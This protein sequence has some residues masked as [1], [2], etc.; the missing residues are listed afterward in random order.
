MH[1]ALSRQLVVWPL[2]PQ[3]TVVAHCGDNREMAVLS[4]DL[5]A[6]S[7]QAAALL[8]QARQLRLKMDSLSP[9]DPQRAELEIIVRDLLKSANSISDVV[10][11][12][13][14]P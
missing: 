3:L 2:P 13:A 8:D 12:G 9:D 5:T 10:K 7:N 11:S 1:A 4:S 6:L 14:K